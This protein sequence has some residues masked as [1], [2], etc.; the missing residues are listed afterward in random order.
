MVGLDIS[1][2]LL[3]AARGLSIEEKVQVDYQISKAEETGL[4]T[5]SFDVVVAGQCWHW[6]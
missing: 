1:E 5:S 2:K 6:F 3:D 4:E